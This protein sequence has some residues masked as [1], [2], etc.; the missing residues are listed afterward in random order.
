[1]KHSSQ[2]VG[3]NFQGECTLLAGPEV[4]GRLH[5]HEEDF[6]VLAGHVLIGR[7]ATNPVIWPSG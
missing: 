7:V 3:W 4:L 1:M 5:L 2:G 6:H